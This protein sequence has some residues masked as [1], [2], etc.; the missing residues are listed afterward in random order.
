[1]RTRLKKLG[2]QNLCHL[3]RGLHVRRTI[4]QESR[5]IL[6]QL[7]QRPLHKCVANIF[8]QP[9]FRLTVKLVHIRQT[10]GGRSFKPFRPALFVNLCLALLHDPLTAGHPAVGNVQGHGIQVS[11]GRPFQSVLLP[12]AYTI[13]GHV[14]SNHDP[15]GGVVP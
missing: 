1:M 11:R 13:I 3:K 2:N 12:D 4:M 8:L 14:V 15:W 10:V 6:F 7:F 5:Y 9:F